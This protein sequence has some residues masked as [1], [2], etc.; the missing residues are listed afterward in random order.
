V[1]ENNRAKEKMVKKAAY[2]THVERR[3]E[4]RTLQQ[5]KQHN[6]KGSTR[7]LCSQ[8]KEYYEGEQ[9]GNEEDPEGVESTFYLKK[10]LFSRKL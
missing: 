9:G 2:L 10:K 4:G 7:V 8:K 5:K 1:G 3:V 6:E